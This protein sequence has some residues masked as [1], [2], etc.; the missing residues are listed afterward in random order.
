MK[1]K[2]KNSTSKQNNNTADTKKTETKPN[3][4]WTGF[5]TLIVAK[6]DKQIKNKSKKINI[7]FI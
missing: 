4:E 3:T 6:A 5:L 1:E 2:A 7:L